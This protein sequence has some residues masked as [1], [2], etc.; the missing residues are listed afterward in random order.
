MFLSS[1]LP[2]LVQSAQE[3]EVRDSIWLTLWTSMA[4]T[5]IFAVAAI[6]FS[7]I[8][9][10]KDFAFKRLVLGIIDLPIVVSGTNLVK[11]A[12][13]TSITGVTSTLNLLAVAASKASS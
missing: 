10:R 8:L 2:E 9:A 3:T 7:Y 4:A 1:S 11:A 12:S 6:P 13:V 5:I